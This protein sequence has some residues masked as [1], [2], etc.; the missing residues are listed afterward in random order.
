MILFSKIFI[1]CVVNSISV[2]NLLLIGSMSKMSINQPKKK[3]PFIKYIIYKKSRENI[4]LK[5]SKIQI[6][7]QINIKE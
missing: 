3:N 1:K 7:S 2:L 5:P 6:N 4:E